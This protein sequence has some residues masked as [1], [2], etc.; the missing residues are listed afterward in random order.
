[1]IP[2]TVE[3]VVFCPSCGQIETLY[4]VGTQLDKTQKYTQSGTS[5][6]HACSTSVPVRVISKQA[7][8]RKEEGT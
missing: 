2:S 8:A 4:G 6:Y 7:Q 1:M 3:I 5:I